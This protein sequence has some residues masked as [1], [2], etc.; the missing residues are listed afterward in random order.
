MVVLGNL[1][2]ERLAR[3]STDLV[4]GLGGNDSQTSNFIGV[5]TCASLINPCDN[6]RAK[7]PD[8]GRTRN[9]SNVLILIEAHLEFVAIA[10][11]AV[12]GR[13]AFTVQSTVATGPVRGPG[14][15]HEFERKPSSAFVKG[16]TSV[17]TEGVRFFD[18]K[19]ESVRQVRDGHLD[20]AFDNLGVHEVRE[21]MPANA[22]G[23]LGEVA[24]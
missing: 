21:G 13:G 1:E 22:A 14:H 20:I 23:H 15:M 2:L 6:H 10:H 9:A 16:F 18:G 12:H 5:S 17:D 4:S 19:V 11:F 3:F 8:A 7:R 24:R